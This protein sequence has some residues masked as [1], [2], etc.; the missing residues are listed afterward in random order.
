MSARS[1]H[2]L[3]ISYY[4]PPMGGGGV[5]R[6]LKFLKYLPAAYRLS[7]L[8]V[9]SSY[10][11]TEDPTL[12]AEVPPKVQVFRSGS[13]DPFRLIHLLKKWLPKTGGSSAQPTRHE[14]GN[15][16]R[17]WAARLFVPDS[18]VLWLPFALLKLWKI[19]RTDRIDLLIA[20]LPPFTAGWIG[21]LAKRW[22][23]I[24]A[25]LDFRDA[26]NNN[27]Y[28]PPTAPG[29][30]YRQQKL[31]RHCLQHASGLIFVNPA[32]E[33]DYRRRF[34][35]IRDKPH[36]TIRNGY[37]PAD[38]SG[39]PPADAP[40]T[41][42]TEILHIGIMGTVYSQGNHPRPLLLALQM[43]Q[44]EQPALA[45]RLHLTFLGKWTPE[46]PGE[47]QAMGLAGQVTFKPYLPQRDALSYA[48]TH[49]DALALAIDSRLPGS[50]AVTPGRIYEYLYLRK[51]ILALC[52]PDGDLAF[53]VRHCQAGEVVEY[54]HLEGIYRVLQDWIHQRPSPG[55]R[56]R[57][58]HIEAFSRE[59]QTRKLQKF[60]DDFLAGER[61]KQ[62]PEPGENPAPSG[63]A[64]S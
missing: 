48:A 5:Q 62:P 27:P 22:L 34:P 38:F 56:Y 30:I 21:I 1:R 16:L 35:F 63:G 25:I 39:P 54:Q 45:A 64:L 59:E 57:F 17:K 14:S 33:S 52:P 37:D 47:V 3:F 50:A 4:F 10:F 24:P 6:V 51:P 19:H 2:V 7:V 23:G 29:L 60:I 42:R 49:F 13:L 43:M 26:W 53:L 46:F 11:Y 40:R 55:E 9:R 32:L 28:L 31:E 18:R 58:V 61:E 8:T 15:R 41:R 20:T 12:A 36:L 44:R